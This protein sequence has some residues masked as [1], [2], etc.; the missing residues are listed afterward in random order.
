MENNDLPLVSVVIPCYNHEQFVQDSIQ[1]VID[2]TYLNIELIIIDDGSKDSSVEKIQ[3]MIPTCEQRFTRFEFRSRPNKGLSATLNEALTWCGGKYYSAIASDDMMFPN[4]T[5][6]QVS[7]LNGH[8]DIVA[9]F[10]GVNIID[11]NNKS[12]GVWLRDEATYRFDDILLHKHELPAPTALVRLCAIKEAGGYKANLKIEDWYM[13]LKISQNSNIYYKNIIFCKYRRH[14]Y[15]TS[16]NFSLM[17]LERF[18]VLNEFRN[19]KDFDI[20]CKNIE[21][22]N[23]SEYLRVNCYKSFYLYF[24][25]LI[26]YPVFFMRK[27]IFKVL[28]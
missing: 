5:E 15:N 1:S 20:A 4:K 7:F 25:I 26:K 27:I 8:A 14:G 21:W 10:G 23:A 28:K 17:H 3:Q 9:I 19:S 13:W 12:V 11:E 22:I 2:Q 24:H 18:K 16:A 6:D